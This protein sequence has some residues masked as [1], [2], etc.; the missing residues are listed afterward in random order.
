MTLSGQ[1]LGSAVIVLVALSHPVSDISAY[2]H[3]MYRIGTRPPPAAH[4]VAGEYL[5]SVLS[6][7]EWSDNV[8]RPNSTIDGKVAQT[9]ARVFI[10][11]IGYVVDYEAS[12]AAIAAM[13]YL[14]EKIGHFM[15]LVISELGVEKVC[16]L[17]IFEEQG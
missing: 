14:I 4:P 2:F 6:G 5:P 10:T 1:P 15:L 12:V 3:L 9:K 17:R 16:Q 11:L 13:L 7:I 8:H